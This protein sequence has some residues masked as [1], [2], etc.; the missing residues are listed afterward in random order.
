MS[1]ADT[2]ATTWSLADTEPITNQQER[3]MYGITSNEE[4]RFQ[5]RI[6]HPLDQV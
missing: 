1:D 4:M 3:E 6:L 5:E 2:E